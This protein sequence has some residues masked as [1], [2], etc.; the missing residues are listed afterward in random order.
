MAA[1]GAAPDRTTDAMVHNIAAQQRQAGN[2]HFG[3]VAR[4]P[5][6]DGDY[7]RTAIAIRALA[8]YGIEARKA[9]FNRRIE[10]AAAWLRAADPRTTEDRNMQVLGLKWANADDAAIERR[11]R[12]LK[13]LQ[14]SDGGWAQT[15][16]LASDAY[17]TGQTLFALHESGVPAS[18]P[19]YRRGVAYLLR[20]QLDDGSW[21]VSSRAPKFQ[22]YFQSGFPHDHDQWISGSATAWAAIALSYAVPEGPARAALK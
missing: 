11:V 2:W 4:P 20:T 10:R 1:E 5:M 22:P 16:E 17:A 12:D 14:R 8:V 6:E 15:A 18:D 3:G 21:H 19:V 7:S 13:A 9:E